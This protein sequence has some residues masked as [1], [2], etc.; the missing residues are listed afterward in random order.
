[1]LYGTAADKVPDWHLR[2][3]TLRAPFRRS[4]QKHEGSQSS[5]ILRAS[6]CPCVARLLDPQPLPFGLEAGAFQHFWVD[7]PLGSAAMG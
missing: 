3:C 4:M 6:V 7:Y 5:A 1:M 2:K